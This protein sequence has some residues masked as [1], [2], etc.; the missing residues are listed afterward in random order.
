MITLNT[1]LNKFVTDNYS[2]IVHLA[3]KIIKKSDRHVYEEL[4]HHA[5]ESFIKHDRA[6]ELIEKKQAF[7][8]LS[9]I[10]YR[11]YYS[12][13]SPWHKLYR[14]AGKEVELKTGTGYL[15]NISPEQH[16]ERDDM[17]T[18][19][20]ESKEHLRSVWNTAYDLPYDEDPNGLERDLKIESIQGIM[21][22]MEADTVEQWFRV[23]L[24]KMW[25]EQP[26]YSEL[27]RMTNIPRTSIS[28]AV[29]E[30]KEYIKQRIE[31]GNNT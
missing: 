12:G 20:Q 22:D 8:F 18:Y 16:V 1:T 14:Y 9:G 6:E 10:M 29:N 21:E 2:K 26:N 25:L 27:S 7:L 15:A 23:V 5:L 11:N 19:W 4:A 17:G 24:F 30:C 28:Q 31:N 13:T 3:R